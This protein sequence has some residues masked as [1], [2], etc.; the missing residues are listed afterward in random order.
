MIEKSNIGF[1]EKSCLKRN[2]CCKQEDAMET[3]NQQDKQDEDISLRQ[4]MIERLKTLGRFQTQ[5]VGGAFRLVPRHLFVPGVDLEMA[6]SDIPIAT[7]WRD[8][9]AISSSSAPSV[10]AIMLEMLD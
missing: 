3:T 10:M 2:K 7:R 9:Q 8:G 6:Y 4:E 5:A 1:A